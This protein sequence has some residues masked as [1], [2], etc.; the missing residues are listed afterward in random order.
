MYRSGKWKI[1]G[2][3]FKGPPAWVK[4]WDGVIYDTCQELRSL[5][6]YNVVWFLSGFQFHADF[7]TFFWERQFEVEH[8][9]K[10]WVGKQIYDPKKYAK[11]RSE[12]L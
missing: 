7:D 4:A 5:L 10:K 8:Q 3:R 2:R 11:H 1:T 12:H 6:G 9:Y